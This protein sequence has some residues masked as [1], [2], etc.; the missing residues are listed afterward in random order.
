[1]I[2]LVVIL[3][4]TGSEVTDSATPTDTTRSSPRR[5]RHSRSATR[6]ARE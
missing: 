3:L 6:L 4:L 1:M 5:T 2:L